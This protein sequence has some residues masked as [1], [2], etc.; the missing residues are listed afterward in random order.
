MLSFVFK[1]LSRTTDVNILEMFSISLHWAALNGTSI[2]CQ[3]TKLCTLCASHVGQAVRGHHSCAHL[4]CIFMGYGALRIVSSSTAYTL[5][6]EQDARKWRG[7]ELPNRTA[8]HP[9]RLDSSVTV[10]FTNR[11]W[12]YWFIVTLQSD[13]GVNDKINIITRHLTPSSL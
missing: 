9:G 2:S 12:F 6:T 8:S 11:P 5:K 3:R 10:H 1:S 7:K 4:H 13:V